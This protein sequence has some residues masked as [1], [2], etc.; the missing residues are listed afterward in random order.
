ML[1]GSPLLYMVLW[2]GAAMLWLHSWLSA[3]GLAAHQITLQPH[4]CKQIHTQLLLAAAAA[5][6][7]ATAAVHLAGQ[8]LSAA[9]SAPVPVTGLAC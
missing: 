5:A 6:A 1:R 8:V 9:S 7:A 3:S 4:L 2:W